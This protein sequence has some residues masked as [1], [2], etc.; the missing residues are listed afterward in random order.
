MLLTRRTYRLQRICCSGSQTVLLLQCTEQK[1]QNW[2]QR[3]RVRIN[4]IAQLAQDVD[5]RVPDRYVTIGGQ[6]Q[7]R[8]HYLR[9]DL[10]FRAVR[11][12]KREEEEKKERVTFGSDAE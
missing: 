9:N 5:R 2:L 3:F 7:Y 1:V 11:K 10:T 12:I 6:V 8:L 4:P